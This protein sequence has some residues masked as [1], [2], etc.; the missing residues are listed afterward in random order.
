MKRKS[1]SSKKLFVLTTMIF[2]VPFTIFL[3]FY[4]FYIASILDSRIAETNQ[5]R[6]QFYRSFLED[7]LRAIEKFMANLVANDRSYGR[8]R[9]ELTPLDAHLYTASILDKYRDV[10]STQKNASGLFIYTEQNNL[11]RKV[12]RADTTSREREAVD[13]Y[14]R[15]LVTTGEQLGLRGWFTAEI[16]GKNYMFRVLGGH[17]VFTICMVDLSRIHAPGSPAI[18]EPDSYFLYSTTDG[19]ALTSQAVVEQHGV[20]L[21]GSNEDYYISGK[22]KRYFIVQSYSEYAG[23]NLVYLVPYQPL[24]G[25]ID[26]LSLT[27]LIASVVFLLLLI[28]CFWLLKRNFF[29]PLS[30]LVRTIERIRRGNIDAKMK[31]A[32]RIEEFEQVSEAFNAMM[33][34][35]KQLKIVAYEQELE[36][37]Q[38]RL[39]Y[40]QIQIR[41]HFFLNCLKNLYGLAQSENHKRIQEMILVLS[42]YMRSM[43]QE[44][45]ATIPL[46][47]E[48][49]NVETYVLLQQMSLSVPISSTIDVAEDLKPFLIPPLSIL[50][51]VENAVKH[52]IVPNTMLKIN[53]KI[54]LL[55]NEDDEYIN[56]TIL[57]NGPGFSQETLRLLNEGSEAELAARGHIGIANVRRRFDLIYKDKS[58]FFFE[59]TGGSCIEIFIPYREAAGRVR[60]E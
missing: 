34:Q 38:A 52:A 44:S 58:M 13:V 14:L 60:L 9:Y 24:L 49:N 39:Q 32:G 3:L 10:L 48:L 27:M 31:L 22:G 2:A 17:S 30:D 12:F 41:P 54:R 26:P 7:D 35:T 46:Q 23:V 18:A 8:L 1:I 20:T 33:E 51:F 57:D 16:D 43:I 4:N 37:Q 56:I 50:T 5:S 55:Q 42:N 47:T 40:L 45:A 28:V 29:T 11:Y 36:S 15:E 25:K 53:V 21:Q 59:G 19:K 6:A